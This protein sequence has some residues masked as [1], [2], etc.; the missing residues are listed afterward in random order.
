MTDWN[1]SIL[2]GKVPNLSA[3][4]ALDIAKGSSA[5]PTLGVGPIHP[6]AGLTPESNI[7]LIEEIQQH[8][9]NRL[10]RHDDN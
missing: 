9:R 8:E 6:I 7:T 2:R 4:V 10:L 3:N 5:M 1:I